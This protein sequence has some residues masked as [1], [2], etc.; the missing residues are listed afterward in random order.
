MGGIC[1][2]ASVLVDPSDEGMF[3]SS[4][5]TTNDGPRVYSNCYDP[6]GGRKDVF[7]AL[8]AFYVILAVLNLFLFIVACI[9][10]SKR[11]RALR[12]RPVMVI[13]NP[14]AY[15]GGWQPM[16]QAAVPMNAYPQQQQQQPQ[17]EA[18]P[19]TTAERTGP[20]QDGVSELSTPSVA[21]PMAHPPQQMSEKG[22]GP[23]NP[24]AIHEFYGSDR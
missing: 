19:Q 18:V 3:C 24:H 11:N 15:W 22:K 8:S 9:D 4:Y 16:P 10:T 13:Q 5:S 17:Q 14:A 12:N 21:T 2:G 6:F 23:E 1:V 7:V 20:V